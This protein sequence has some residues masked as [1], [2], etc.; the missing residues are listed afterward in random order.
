MILDP[1]FFGLKFFFIERSFD[2]K[3]V[4]TQNFVVPNSF[5]TKKYFW[6]HPYL[7]S[8]PTFFWLTFW[9]QES[10]LNPKKSKFS[11]QAQPQFQLKL[12]VLG[13]VSFILAKSKTQARA[14]LSSVKGMNL[15]R[16]LTNCCCYMLLNI[17]YLLADTCYLP[18]NNCYLINVT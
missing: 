6:L 7:V 15:M 4:L 18:L 17:Y 13:W 3:F 16:L 14:S 12:S 8:E 10:L 9:N 11:C 2:P 5:L 1:T